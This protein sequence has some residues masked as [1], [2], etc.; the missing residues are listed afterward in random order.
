MHSA[1]SNGAFPS[2]LC[3]AAAHPKIPGN[4]FSSNRFS[5]EATALVRRFPWRHIRKE[6]RTLKQY[7]AKNIK[8]IALAGH[9]G[10]GK[11]SLAEALLYFAGATDRLG[12]V[13]DGNTVCDYDAEEVKRQATVATAVA[14]LEWKGDKINLLDTPGL[15]DFA[16]GMCEGIRAAE[17]VLISI[18]GKSG[19]AVGTEKAFEAAGER[20]AAKFFFVNKLDSDHV[21]ALNRDGAQISGTVSFSVPVTAET[22]DQMRGE[23]DI[24]FLMTKQLKNRAA[25]EFLLPFLGSSGVLCTL[26]NGLP[27]PALMEILGE[28]R[29]LGCMKWIGRPL[30]VR[31]TGS[32]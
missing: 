10:S 9:A 31:R 30:C 4:G 19:V 16:E 7:E 15:F 11:T 1:N 14:P 13:A 27:E 32:P 24:I 21:D 5:S 20:G 23:Y 26:Q 12:K 3:N 18:S 8:N 6:F 2:A 17:T 28:N 22:P 29:V 25:A